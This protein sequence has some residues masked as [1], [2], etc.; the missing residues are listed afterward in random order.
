LF[1]GVPS[2]KT[3]VT[4]N[5]DPHQSMVVIGSPANLTH[6]SQFNFAE[7]LA[8]TSCGLDAFKDICG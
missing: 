1:L 3:F 4:I 8:D 5:L 7:D 6:L 2:A